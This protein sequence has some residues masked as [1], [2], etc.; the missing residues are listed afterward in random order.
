LRAGLQAVLSDVSTRLAAD[1]VVLV[2]EFPTLKG[3][4]RL[5]S[6]DVLPKPRVFDR[7]RL[8][9]VKRG[10]AG[11]AVLLGV[12]RTAGGG[13]TPLERRVV[14]TAAE[15]I[16]AWGAPG[17]G[18]AEEADAPS[19]AVLERLA[20]DALER[21]SVVTAVV[22]STAKQQS[23]HTPRL[24]VDHIRRSLRQS[25]EV[26]L[27]RS[28]EVGLLLR[29][30]TAASAAAVTT[31]VETTL[32]HSDDG[33]LVRVSAVGFETR[34]PGQGAAAGII[35][36]ARANSRRRSLDAPRP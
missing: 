1:A 2:A 9:V 5:G 29:D 32:R 23:A 14:E 4:V 20:Q 3:P 15:S 25:D 26:C 24:R 33:A 8:A 6:I 28:G 27:L 35:Q 7:S 36:A 19:S 21:G 31:R 34:L 18:R 13:F 11:E 12:H 30:T 16:L 10:D 17:T 22:L